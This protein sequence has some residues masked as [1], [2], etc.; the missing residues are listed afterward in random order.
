MQ[1]IPPLSSVSVRAIRESPLQKGKP[2]APRQ[3]RGCKESKS[4]SAPEGSISRREL[5]LSPSRARRG[6]SRI[7]R[8]KTAPTN[9]SAACQI[10]IYQLLILRFLFYIIRFQNRIT[11]RIKNFTIESFEALFYC[12]FIFKSTVFKNFLGF[13]I[14]R[15]MESRQ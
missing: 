12:N 15:D 5:R 3:S 1:I 10:G 4:L 14:I 9:V 13:D 8:K 6:D 7:A 11:N 2:F